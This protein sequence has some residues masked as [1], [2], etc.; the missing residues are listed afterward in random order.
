MAKA[1][2]IFGQCE[3]CGCEDYLYRTPEGM[4]C[5]GTCERLLNPKKRSDME[6]FTPLTSFFPWPKVT[7][8][9]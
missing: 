5:S 7:G 9:V 4:V 8:R 3:V 6:R 2:N 1:K